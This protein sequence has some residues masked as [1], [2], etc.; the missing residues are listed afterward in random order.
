MYFGPP[1]DGPFTVLGGPQRPRS[2]LENNNNKKN[3]HQKK[4]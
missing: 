1:V 4:K 3:K 2:L